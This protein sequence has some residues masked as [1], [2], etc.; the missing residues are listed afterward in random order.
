M[1]FNFA[2]GNDFG[3]VAQMDLANEQMR[4]QGW[5]NAINRL[6]NVMQNQQMIK[7][8][9]KEFAV[10]SANTARELAN[11][12]AALEAQKENYNKV[13]QQGDRAFGLRLQELD[14]SKKQWE[15][16]L[17][18]EQKAI[19]GQPT[20]QQLQDQAGQWDMV[21]GE[22]NSGVPRPDETEFEKRYPGLTPVQRGA[23]LRMWG[24]LDTKTGNEW[25]NSKALSDMFN[26]ELSLK[27]LVN[28]VGA[29]EIES[30][31][32]N[33]TALLQQ[34]NSKL[35]TMTPLLD[36]YRKSLDK[37]GVMFDGQQFR[38]IEP[39][40]KTAPVR[41]ILGG[42][43]PMS[44]QTNAPAYIPARDKSG[45]WKYIGSGNPLMDK[46]SDNWIPPTQ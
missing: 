26:N 37:F 16:R 20:K 9:A 4:S 43:A 30:R 28:V 42:G 11:R 21:I 29:K 6:Q 19:E 22:I 7:Q 34:S 25:Q 2:Y 35:A 31:T 18:L 41:S 33:D 27:R 38:P 17:G 44:Q 13:L 8:R 14:Q 45:E 15:D 5:E 36:Q 39:A 24:S 10:Q 23:A 12:E 32:D 3:G 40:I 46:N 1:A